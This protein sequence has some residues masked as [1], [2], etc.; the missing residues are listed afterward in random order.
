[1]KAKLTSKQKLA[2]KISLVQPAVTRWGPLKACFE[3]LLQSE[4]I[5]QSIVTARDFIEDNS[6]QKKSRQ[7]VFDVVTSSTFVSNLKKSI[8]ILTPIDAAIVLFQDDKISV[9]TVYHILNL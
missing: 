5:L 2:G 4:S 3:S 8:L 1:M 9:S 6:K 7:N